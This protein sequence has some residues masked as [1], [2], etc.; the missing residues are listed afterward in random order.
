MQTQQPLT[1]IQKLQE[2]LKT[3]RVF[4]LI[5]NKQH[6]AVFMSW[7]VFAV[8]DFMSL[9]KSLQRQLTS[10]ETLWLPPVNPL[11]SRLIND[12]VLGEE[13][14]EL[15]GGGYLSHFE[16]YLQAMREIGAD[17]AQIETFISHLYANGSIDKAF[18]AAGVDQGIRSFVRHTLKDV[19]QGNL[20]RVLGNFFYGRE[21]IIPQMF[22]S[23]LD[24]WQLDETQAPMFVYYLK[25]HIEL[26]GDT[27]GPAAQ[28]IILQLTH[29][30]PEALHQL[31]TSAQQAINARIKFWDALAD[32]LLKHQTPNLSRAS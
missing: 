14:D 28:K 13:S 6:L 12:I 20:H 8:W 4:S 1:E 21:D 25:R 15:P 9:V 2:Q 17:T 18:T 3:H 32:E 23:L 31:Q 30:K 24:E 26:D 29:D 19:N 16:M 10:I 22:Q 11:A 27:H 7:H 5:Q